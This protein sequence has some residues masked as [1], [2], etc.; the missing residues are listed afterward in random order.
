MI[1]SKIIQCFKRYSQVHSEFGLIISE[2][3]LE[4]FVEDLVQKFS[5]DVDNSI[6][7]HKGS[8]IVSGA[9]GGRWCEDCKEMIDDKFM[10]KSGLYSF[11]KWKHQ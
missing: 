5:I 3:N 6:C 2:M 11:T 9:F 10:T 1:E 7:D 4:R 8:Y